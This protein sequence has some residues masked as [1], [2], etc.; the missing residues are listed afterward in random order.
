MS[1]K[2][3]FSIGSNAIGSRSRLASVISWLKRNYGPVK[4]T[5][6]YNTPELSGRFANYSNALVIGQTDEALEI[7]EQRLKTME[8]N[9]GRTSQSKVKGTV[10]IDIDLI[11]SGEQLVRSKEIG[12]PYFLYGWNRIGN[13]W[14]YALTSRSNHQ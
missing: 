12:R 5:E 9:Y 7:T 1:H 2:V 4:A 3:L 10:E 14:P 13:F 11:A 6:I 8:R